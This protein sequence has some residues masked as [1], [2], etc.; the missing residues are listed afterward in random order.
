MILIK[1]YAFNSEEIPDLILYIKKLA[2]TNM[3]KKS[4]VIIEDYLNDCRDLDIKL[5][6]DVTSLI[7][8]DL[9]S[10]I[11]IPID[12]FDDFSEIDFGLFSDKRK[13]TRR[14]EILYKK[15]VDKNNKGFV[16]FFDRF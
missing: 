2:V 10:V 9:I 7:S 12:E 16:N 8:D 13:V 6:K 15:I 14:D 3:D 11:K 1:D 4:S 5:Q